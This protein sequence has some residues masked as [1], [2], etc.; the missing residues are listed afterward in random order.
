MNLLLTGASGFIGRNLL[1]HAPADWRIVALY[2]NSA[3]F[4]QFVT[5][6]KNP[7]ITS[8][9]CDLED[10]Q[11]VARFFHE[12]G[13]RWENCLYLAAK[14]D[15][16]WSVREPKQDLLVNTG[17]LLNLLE[18]LHAKQFVYFSSGAV[19]DGLSGEIPPHTPF[20]PTFAVRH[21]QAGL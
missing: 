17:A 6:L 13:N 12:Q 19:Y 8:V 16:P 20:S 11:Q 9:Q 7:N 10:S 5:A 21:L 1:L 15:I 14:V 18:G 2:R 4:P 3:T